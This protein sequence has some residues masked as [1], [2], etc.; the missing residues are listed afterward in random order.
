MATV[1]DLANLSAMAYDATKTVFVDWKR[2]EQYG[3]P[4]GQGFYAELYLHRK[5]KEVVMS[6][7]GTD[8]DEKDWSDLNSDIQI[9]LGKVPSQLQHAKKAYDQF[10][11]RAKKEFRSN[12][13]LYLTGHS[14]G[15]GL[16][17][18]LSAK[19]AGL[20][21]VTFNAPGMQRSYI[22]SHLISVIGYI[23]L[24]YVNTTQMLHIRATGDPVSIGTGKHMGTVEEIYVDNWGDGKLLG[25]SRHL[26]QHSIQ[27][28][29]R[30]LKTKPW[31]HQDLGFQLGYV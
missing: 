19:N 17:S 5:T 20:P 7:R 26:A 11:Q 27:N 22:G 24:Q 23:N 12:F 14:L 13:N 1:F 3:F 30:S 21:T 16:A 29:V 15:G 2:V 9:A 25:S 10:I 31:Y 28:M 4:F 8:F 18:L 6:I